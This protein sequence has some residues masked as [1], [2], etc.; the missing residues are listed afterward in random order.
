MSAPQRTHSVAE[1]WPCLVFLEILPGVFLIHVFV[2]MYTHT[3]VYLT[4]T[5]IYKYMH[6]QQGL[7]NQSLK[8]YD[9]IS[10]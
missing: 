3:Y 2:Y 1:A 4:H 6:C 9:L 7:V 5:H 8:N 10:L